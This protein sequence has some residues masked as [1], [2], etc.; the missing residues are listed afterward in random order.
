MRWLDLYLDGM[1][2]SAFMVSGSLGPFGRIGAVANV[3]FAG[4]L[5]VAGVVLGITSQP[6][7]FGVALVAAVLELVFLRVAF[8]T[9]RG[10]FEEFVLDPDDDPDDD[11]DDDDPA[12]VE[13]RD[14]TR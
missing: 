3:V 11:A 7:G 5:L 12:A 14:A 10:D 9:F 13:G 2:R 4:V 8:R 6:P 1:H